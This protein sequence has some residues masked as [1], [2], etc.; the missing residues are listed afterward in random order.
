MQKNK[1]RC[2]KCSA[3][4]HGNGQASLT[5]QSPCRP[6]HGFPRPLEPPHEGHNN[7]GPMGRP[8]SLGA[9]RRRWWRRALA[10]PSEAAH[11]RRRAHPAGAQ[12]RVGVTEGV[13]QGN[14]GHRGIHGKLLAGEPREV[15]HI[16][17]HSIVPL[18]P[19]ELIPRVLLPA[20]G[21]GGV[22]RAPHE[23]R[24]HR[25][26]VLYQRG[27]GAQAL[28]VADTSP[29]ALVHE[30]GTGDTD[31]LLPPER[32][33]GRA[34]AAVHDEEVHLPEERSEV[35]VLHLDEPALGL[36]C[37]GPDCE[38]VGHRLV[39]LQSADIDEAQVIAALFEHLETASH[40]LPPG[41]RHAAEGHQ[42]Q[43]PAARARLPAESGQWLCQEAGRRAAAEEDE[44]REV[45]GLPPVRG[46]REGSLPHGD[47][48]GHVHPPKRVPGVR[49]RQAEALPEVVE[50]EAHE[51]ALLDEALHE[52][53]R[54]VGPESVARAGFALAPAHRLHCAPLLVV[55]GDDRGLQDEADERLAAELADEPRHARHGEAEDQEVHGPRAVVLHL[56]DVGEEDG[57][58]AEKL[59]LGAGQDD[60]LHQ[61]GPGLKDALADP[62]VHARLR[63]AAAGAELDLAPRDLGVGL[64]EGLPPQL[65]ADGHQPPPLLGHAARQRHEGLHVAPRAPRHHE[66]VVGATCSPSWRWRAA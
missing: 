43:L 1:S 63:V 2:H 4:V 53:Q 24:A 38:I 37:V 11:Q 57:G 59:C 7:P 13:N 49:N 29:E 27:L 48:Q 60:H 41:H 56:Q 30:Q 39:S 28:L 9:V 65:C 21:I 33:H 34:Q 35:G 40:Y 55:A 12:E 62:A 26:E 61:V 25:L 15:L 22:Q 51:A 66:D 32:L 19:P 6:A 10:A 46:P 50:V 44:V 64:H 54:G 14:G 3:S 31:R 18:R 58:A 5:E 23:L 8:R 16:D 45:Y 47:D 17:V 20:A 42:T 36:E 52:A